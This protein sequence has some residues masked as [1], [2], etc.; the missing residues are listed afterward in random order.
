MEAI[1]I[2]RQTKIVQ[3]N[4]NPDKTQL[5]K[6]IVSIS[7]GVYL[8]SYD[9]I[10]RLE[11]DSNYCVIHIKGQD[12][13]LSSKPLKFYENKLPTEAFSRIHKAHLV[14]LDH[15]QLIKQQ[16]VIMCDKSVC[17]ISRRQ[18]SELMRSIGY[19]TV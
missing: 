12:S 15:I 18:R 8:L 17:P 10:I 9:Q 16:E 1:S 11:A 2:N 6:L 14:A 3:I 7:E 13:I 4:Q 5:D 19:A